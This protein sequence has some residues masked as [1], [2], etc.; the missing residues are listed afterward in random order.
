MVQ[1]DR[2]VEAKPSPIKVKLDTALNS[3]GEFDQNKIGLNFI[4]C[5]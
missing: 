1:V 5:G 3:D 4:I 2:T